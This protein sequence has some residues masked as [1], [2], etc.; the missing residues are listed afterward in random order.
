MKRNNIPGLVALLIMGLTAF[1][2]TSD[3]GFLFVIQGLE[4]RDVLKEGLSPTDFTLLTIKNDNKSLQVNEFEIV[5]ARGQSPVGL[6]VT[7]VHGNS[8]SLDK[9]RPF[10][11]T[12]DRLVVKVRTVNGEQVQSEDAIFVIPIR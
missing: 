1:R 7:V 10:A 6:P 12:G 3:N 11:K 4:G 2:V 9:F 8:I 5:L